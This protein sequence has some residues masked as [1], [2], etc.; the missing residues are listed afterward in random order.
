MSKRFR[1]AFSFAGEKRD[2]VERVAAI[3][4][5]GQLG[6]GH[7][8]TFTDALAFLRS[9]PKDNDPLE[10]IFGDLAQE[11]TEDEER[12][13]AALTYFTLTARVEHIA[14]VASLEEAVAEKALHALANRS[15]VTPDQ[16]EKE[17]ALVPLV[18]EFLRS[19]RPEAVRVTGQHLEQR[20]YALIM[21]NGWEEHARFPV[22]DSAWPSVAPAIPLFVAGKNAR[23]QAVCD[24]LQAFLNFTGRWDERLSLSGQGERK[25]L[26]AEDHDQAGWRAYDAGV[27]HRLRQ[28]AG[29]VLACAVGAE[30]HWKT[31]K[32]GAREQAIAIGLLGSGHQL[33]GD[34]LSAITAFRKAIELDRGLSTESVDMAIDLNSLAEAERLSGDYEAAERN[35]REALRVSRA[36]GYAEGVATFTGNLALLARDRKDWQGA[37]ALARETLPLCEKLGHLVLIAA[38]S[39]SLAEALVRQGSAA[40]ALPYA[41][42]AAEIY[43]RL[44]SPSLA[45]AQAIFRECEEAKDEV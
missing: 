20:A 21:E 6:R 18:A 22:L 17:Y 33:N 5:A 23:L 8:R 7:C 26:T 43:T 13:L 42:R 11:F 41:C 44:G 1:I 34:Y 29:E 37:E 24:A 31:A 38:N 19:H 40:E 35:Y 39:I 3:L 9:C 16:E 25:A 27:V 45:H 14:A 4:A 36:V 12:V 30:E 32:A 15:L 28:Q 2:F 10:F